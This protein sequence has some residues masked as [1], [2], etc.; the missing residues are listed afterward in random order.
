VANLSD[1]QDLTIHQPVAVVAAIEAFRLAMAHFA[2]QNDF[3][4][5][6]TTSYI[7]PLSL[8]GNFQSFLVYHQQP[9]NFVAAKEA[10]D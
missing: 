9:I 10:V 6:Y 3:Y 8:S 5:R 4:A 1:I 7:K 2:A